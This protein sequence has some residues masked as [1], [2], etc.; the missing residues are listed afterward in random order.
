MPP[1]QRRRTRS[2]IYFDADMY[3]PRQS[4]GGGTCKKTLHRSIKAVLGGS[5][6]FSCRPASA[7]LKSAAAY[8]EN[9]VS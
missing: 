8:A 2:P 7:R 5:L 6:A 9:A 3:I 4:A 1:M